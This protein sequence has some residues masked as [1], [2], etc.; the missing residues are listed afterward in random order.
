MDGAQGKFDFTYSAA[1]RLSRSLRFP[2]FLDLREGKQL[3]RV[4]RSA[5]VS[6]LLRIEQ[7]AGLSGWCWCSDQSLADQS[8]VSLSQTRRVLRVLDA[9]ALIIVIVDRKEVN[10]SIRKI[11]PH[12]QGY[13]DS[14]F[15]SLD[16]DSKSELITELLNDYESNRYDGKTKMKRADS[17]AFEKNLSGGVRPLRGVSSAPEASSS[18]PEASSSTPVRGDHDIMKSNFKVSLRRHECDFANNLIDGG[19]ID[20]VLEMLGDVPLDLTLED[21]WVFA[22]KVACFVCCGHWPES[23]WFDSLESLRRRQRS[24]SVGF[25][26]WVGTIKRMALA[27]DVDIGVDLK[28]IFLPSELRWQ[29]ELS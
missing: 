13:L 29:G 21:D 23:W 10:H 3:R 16:E 19:V 26:Y 1:M 18:T 12:W 22:C 17:S 7:Y 20:R 28:S 24:K 9:S 2:E 11:R 25:G 14:D 15:C 5:V 4:S 27:A 6:V 8:G